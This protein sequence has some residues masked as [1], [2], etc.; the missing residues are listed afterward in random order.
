MLGEVNRVLPK[1]EQIPELWWHAGKYQQL[2]NHHKR[3]F[4]NSRLR[5]RA[6][7]ALVVLYSAFAVV[8]FFFLRT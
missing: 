4:P 7:L 2:W 3:L 1:E 6:Q 5:S 8:A